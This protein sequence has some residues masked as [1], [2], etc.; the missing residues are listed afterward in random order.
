MLHL[1]P[2][3]VCDPWRDG[4]VGH[5]LVDAS[6][7]EDVGGILLQRLVVA[8]HAVVYFTWRAQLRVSHPV[9]D[10]LAELPVHAPAAFY[11]TKVTDKVLEVQ[12][13]GDEVAVAVALAVFADDGWSDVVLVPRL[14][15]WVLHKLVFESRNE[16]LKGISHNEKLKVGVQSV[17]TQN[18]KTQLNTD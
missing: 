12:T 15:T 4:W 18:R 17:K 7:F 14:E 13:R 5:Q 3:V 9:N 11:V 16:A 1:C 8:D 2:V 6:C 10:V